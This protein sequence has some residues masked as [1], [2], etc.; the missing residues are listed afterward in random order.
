M[1]LRDVLEAMAF[2]SPSLHSNPRLPARYRIHLLF[3]PALHPAMKRVQ[4][5][6]RA[7]GFRTIFNLAGPSPIRP[8]RPPGHGVYAPAKLPS[9]PSHGQLGIR[10]GRVVH[11]ATASTRSRSPH[12]HDPRRAVSTTKHRRPSHVVHPKTPASRRRSQLAAGGDTPQSNAAI[13]ESILIGARAARSATWS[14][15]TG[16]RPRSHRHRR[17][18]REGVARAAEAIDSGRP[19]NP[20]CSS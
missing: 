12:R 20:P 7:L 19:Q 9:S 1:W 5:V 16:C 13:L 10:F 8:T 15:S 17:G 14:S 2:P 6:R 4:P 11:A 18:L 3:A